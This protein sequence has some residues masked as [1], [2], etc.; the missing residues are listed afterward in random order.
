MHQFY[1]YQL[2]QINVNLYVR[3][4]LFYVLLLQ[5]STNARIKTFVQKML[6]ARTTSEATSAPATK[7]SKVTAKIAPTSTNALNQSRVIRMRRV[8]T[9]LA[10]S[11]ASAPMVAR[12]VKVSA[13]R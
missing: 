11:N 7:D 13:S 9:H 1:A 12:V 8:K 4:S 5:T 2:Y 10:A 6:P 3:F